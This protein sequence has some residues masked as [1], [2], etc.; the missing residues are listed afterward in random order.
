MM[1]NSFPRYV[2]FDPAVP[3]WCVTPERPGCIHRFFD[4]SPI[5][6]SGRYLAVLQM[7]FEDHLPAPGDKG[8]IVLVDLET[9][10]ARELAESAGWEPQMGAN[11]NWGGSDEQLFFNDVDIS[12]WTPYAWKLNPL[13]G[14]KVRMEGPVY[15]ASPDGKWLIASNP[16]TMFRT[17]P[18]Y[19]ARI[20]EDRIKRNIGPVSDVCWGTPCR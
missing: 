6:P 12:S 2:D 20:P 13:T 3:V 19:G 15:H 17:Q 18:G 11:I 16:A 1:H 5:S 10:K 7:P 4:T 9:G 8:T 14:D